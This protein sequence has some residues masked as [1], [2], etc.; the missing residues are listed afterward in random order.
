M[1]FEIILYPVHDIQL[2]YSFLRFKP[3]FTY[4]IKSNSFITINTFLL[5]GEDHYFRV[6]RIEYC[7][8]NIRNGQ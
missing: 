7:D 6:T 4:L 1:K 8:K 3:L 5:L 2:V